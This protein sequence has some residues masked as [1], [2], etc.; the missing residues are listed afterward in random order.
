MNPKVRGKPNVIFPNVKGSAKKKIHSMNDDIQY[1]T[2]P[3]EV[4]KN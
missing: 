1:I 2:D 3:E 4:I